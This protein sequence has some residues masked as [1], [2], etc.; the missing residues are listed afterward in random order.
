MN[1][2]DERDRAVPIRRRQGMMDRGGLQFHHY[3]VHAMFE[4]LIHR[5]WGTVRWHPQVDLHEDDE[6]FT[7]EIDLPGVQAEDIRVLVEGKTVV[8]EGRRQLRKC[9]EGTTHLCER[10]DGWFSRAFAFD[11]AIRDD[12]IESRWQDGVLTVTVPKRKIDD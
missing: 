2:A 9:E 12:R 1:G 6:A 8:I 11:E 5:P 4:E 10:P 3:E 7:I